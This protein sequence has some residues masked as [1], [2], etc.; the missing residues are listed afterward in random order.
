MQHRNGAPSKDHPVDQILIRAAMTGEI[1][2][3]DTDMLAGY[4]QILRVEARRTARLRT[5]LASPS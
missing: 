4:I 3:S 1:S 5:T 2:C